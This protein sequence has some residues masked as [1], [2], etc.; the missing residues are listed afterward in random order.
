VNF[1]GSTLL[2]LIGICEM[3]E[4]LIPNTKNE[5]PKYKI[6][7]RTYI[8]NLQSEFWI[9]HKNDSLLHKDL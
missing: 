3:E 2:H 5:S 1:H 9:H 8:K 7:P 4:D 6:L